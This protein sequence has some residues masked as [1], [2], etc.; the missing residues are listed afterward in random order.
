MKKSLIKA[1][2]VKSKKHIDF[3]TQ[4]V[5]TDVYKG[6]Y[7]IVSIFKDK[8]PYKEGGTRTWLKLESN[9]DGS[10]IKRLATK[11]IASMKRE[12]LIQEEGNPKTPRE[13]INDCIEE[14][15]QERTKER[16]DEIKELR[17][18]CFKL[19][20]ELSSAQKKFE[21]A[22][23]NMQKFKAELD[24]LKNPVQTVIKDT[25]PKSYI[26]GSTNG[27]LFSGIKK[28]IFGQ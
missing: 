21:N 25:N 9:K 4:Y 11:I 14:I 26:G 16:V 15:V 12:G 3:L 27:T 2:E 6:K 10:Q 8:N 19:E 22:E 1:H 17:D 5:G 18:R 28:R 7:K 23:Y 24:S 20:E 13:K